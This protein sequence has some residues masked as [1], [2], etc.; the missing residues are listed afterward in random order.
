MHHLGKHHNVFIRLHD[1]FVIVV[2]RGEDGWSGNRSK[3]HDATLTQRSLLHVIERTRA[4]FVQ[5][6]SCPGSMGEIIHQGL[7]FRLTPIGNQF[8]T[9]S[10]SGRGDDRSAIF[11]VNH[12]A[13]LTG[14]QPKG[15]IPSDAATFCGCFAIWVAGFVC[16]CSASQYG[17]FGLARLFCSDG[18]FLAQCFWPL[19]GRNG[20]DIIEARQIGLAVRSA[21]DISICARTRQKK[22]QQGNIDQYLHLSLPLNHTVHY[23]PMP[24]LGL[25]PYRQPPASR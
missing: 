8:W 5:P 24:G 18:L 13:F 22:T 7:R 1:T 25:H 2:D 12:N 20:G 10:I 4:L 21:R 9:S 3:A 11:T 6:P 16:R 14:V 19:H 15:V 17:L 23:T